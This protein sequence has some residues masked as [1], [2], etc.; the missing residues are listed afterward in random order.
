MESAG[1]RCEEIGL[2]VDVAAATATAMTIVADADRLQQ[3]LWNVLANAVKFTPKGGR[4]EIRATR[5]GSDVSIE[6]C[7]TGEEDRARDSASHVSSTP[8][9]KPDSSATRRHGG[10][11]LGLALVKKLARSP[12][13]ASRGR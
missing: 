12:W 4:V 6:I 2:E 3:I 13:G 11:G 1:T 8:F 9:A 10:L 5:A 7:D